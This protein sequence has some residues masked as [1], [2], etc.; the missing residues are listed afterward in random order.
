[1]P[2]K[3]LSPHKMVKHICDI[4]PVFLSSK[5]ITTVLMDLDNTL[6]CWNSCTVDEQ[7][8]SWIR[9]AKEMGLKLCIVSNNKRPRIEKVAEMLQIPFIYR[10]AKPRKG[11]YLKALQEMHSTAQETVFIGDQLFT[12]VF[13][14]NRM[15]LYTILVKPLHA[16]EFVGTKVMRRVE[17]LVMRHITP[18]E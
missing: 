9:N 15:K 16:R 12:D 10:A 3:N 4:D 13:G 17:K 11:A 6:T 14:A 8:L 18:K 5:G 2:F 7:V 1:M